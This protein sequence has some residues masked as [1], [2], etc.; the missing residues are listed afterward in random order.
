MRRDAGRLALLA[1]ASVA[2][3][4]A[5][6]LEDPSLALGG[7]GACAGAAAGLAAPG[8]RSAAAAAEVR[9]L[10]VRGVAIGALVGL[11]FA[12]Q[13]DGALGGVAHPR[14]VATLLAVLGT[15]LAARGPR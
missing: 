5:I 3:Y 11:V 7:G 8:L 14:A 2:W 10:V 13:R 4:F 6:A 15:L 9:R 12:W 1:V